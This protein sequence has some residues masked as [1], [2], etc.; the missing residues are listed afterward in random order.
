MLLLLI[1]LSIL[2][3]ILILL[4]IFLVFARTD[5]RIPRNTPRRDLLAAPQRRAA[6][7]PFI[8]HS[9][10]AIASATSGGSGMRD[11]PRVA[12]MARCT[13]NFDA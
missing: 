4:L 1:L 9:A 10:T 3:L 12:V 13:C 6:C 11:S 2:F 8:A 7:S 5:T